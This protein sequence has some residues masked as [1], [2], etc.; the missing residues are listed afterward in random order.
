MTSMVNVQM[1]LVRFIIRV[2][3]LTGSIR[4]SAVN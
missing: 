1:V 2:S 4:Q 3:S